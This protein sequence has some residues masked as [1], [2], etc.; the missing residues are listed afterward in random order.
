M[1]DHDL[2]GYGQWEPTFD[3]GTQCASGCGYKEDDTEEDA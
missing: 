1:T 2:F 3:S